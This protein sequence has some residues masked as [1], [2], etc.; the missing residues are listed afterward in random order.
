MQCSSCLVQ[1]SDPVFQ[2]VSSIKEQGQH[3]APSAPQSYY[4]KLMKTITEN[5]DLLH[6]EVQ[7]LRQNQNKLMERLDSIEK[8]LLDKT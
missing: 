7:Y 5:F 1:N 4:Q 2:Q 8:T 3:A 6:Q